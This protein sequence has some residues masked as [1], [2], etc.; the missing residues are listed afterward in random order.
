MPALPVPV[1]SLPHDPKLPAQYEN[2][3][4]C[5][6]RFVA[7][8]VEKEGGF[9]HQHTAPWCPTRNG[10]RTRKAA[11]KCALNLTGMARAPPRGTG[12]ARRAILDA[13]GGTRPTLLKNCWA[14][15]LVGFF[16]VLRP[17]TEWRSSVPGRSERSTISLVACEHHPFEFFNR[18]RNAVIRTE[19]NETPP[20][21]GFQHLLVTD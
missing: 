5:C 6:R 14:S 8:M 9:R 2:D 19:Q 13:N 21:R 12:R 10:L 3:K 1:R 11:K 17:S 16:G 15:S 7:E 4:L 18:K 20:K